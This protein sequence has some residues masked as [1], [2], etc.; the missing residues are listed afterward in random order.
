MDPGAGLPQG[1]QLVPELGDDDRVE[2]ARLVRADPLV[3]AVV[4]SRLSA[5]VPLVPRRF[6]GALIGVRD[7]AGRLT[8]AAFS[9]G[10]LLPVGGDREAWT[11]LAAHVA[12]RARVATSIVGRAEAVE[13]M[14]A[15]LEPV[16]GPARAI[17]RDQRLLR[18]DHA[19]AERPA[20]VGLRVASP[21]EIER[22]LPA[23][24]AM[25]TEELGVSPFA[26]AGA[27]G[28]R[29]RIAALLREGRALCVT[30]RSGEVLFKA[31]LG[32]V[33]PRTCQIQGVWVRPDLRGRGLGT[34][35]MVGVLDHALQR[36]P[37]ASL[38]VN[39]FNVAARRM[40]ESLGMTHSA[41]LATVLL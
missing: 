5:L 34:T 13:A 25:F 40:Y 35:A 11:A 27:G 10:N 20:D 31:D 33:T 30:D 3:N 29:G 6:G 24:A 12:G 21:D 17:R 19:V 1:L 28:Y 4:D 23:A 32:V 36:A 38:Y 15:V 18:L 37:T 8:A 7:A 14:W 39:D 26:G 16:W 22:Y 41:T 9:G 2:L